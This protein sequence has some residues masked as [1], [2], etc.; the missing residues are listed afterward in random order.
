MKKIGLLIGFALSAVLCPRLSG[1]TNE[2]STALQRGLFEEEANHNFQAALQSYQ[3]AIASYDESRKMAATALYRLGEVYRKLGKTN[4]AAAQYERLLRDFSDQPDLVAAAQKFVGAIAN[5]PTNAAVIAERD[6]DS[7]EIRRLQKLIAETPDLV[8]AGSQGMGNT[9]LHNAAR[10]GHLAVVQ[11]LLTNN[12]NVNAQDAGGRTPLAW[13][14]VST[15]T[16]RFNLEIV[17]ALLKAH[18]DVDLADNWG[19]S[20][21]H[22]AAFVASKPKLDLLLA[23]GANLNRQANN[24]GTP[25]HYAVSRGFRVGIEA[26]LKKGANPNLIA[27][28]RRQVEIAGR[29]EDVMKSDGTPLHLAVSLGFFATAE[30]LIDGGADVN[31]STSSRTTPLHYAVNFRQPAIAKLLLDHNANVDPQTEDGVTPL[32]QAA[33]RADLEM[34]KLLLNHHANPKI[35]N[36]GQVTPMHRIMES[37]HAA[38]STNIIALL[39]DAG[40]DPNAADS[41]GRTPLLSVN[42]EVSASPETLAAMNL[43]L[44]RGANPNSADRG[45]QLTA[46]I[47]AAR[48]ANLPMVKLLLTYHANPNHKSINGLTALHFLCSERSRSPDAPEIA[49]ALITA[50]ANVNAITDYGRTPL[51]VLANA[52]ASGVIPATPMPQPRFPGRPGPSLASQ[53]PPENKPLWDVLVQNGAVEQMADFSKVTSVRGALNGSGELDKDDKG[54]NHFTL[55]ELIAQSYF[56]TDGQLRSPSPV[57][58]DGLLF[59]DFTGVKILRPSKSDPKSTQEIHAYIVTA[60]DAFDCSRDQ[61]LEFGDRVDIPE[62]SHSL[63]SVDSGLSSAQFQSL[64]D[65]LRRTITV[66]IGGQ[67]QDIKLSGTL[68]DTYLASALRLPEIQALLRNTSDL[69]AINVTRVNPKT[70]E[71]Q[72]IAEDITPFWNHQKRFADD[73]WLRAGDKVEVNEKK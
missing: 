73:L 51:S 20:P 6:Y 58:T 45:D 44:K 40:A 60:Q 67:P 27:Y 37:S 47:A 64:K 48:H 22:L 24:G 55:Y 53:A 25:L 33:S 39:L 9:P 15:G 46:I 50:G 8:N 10:L 4:D 62:K 18:A 19:Q 49:R 11:F 71:Q 5:T 30:A 2:I 63:T 7:E 12:V 3:S 41:I 26:L 42:Y 21:L 17:D 28:S 61:D 36:S 29:T 35:A 13:A 56:S 69:T 32:S 31:V 72:K 59:P 68:K 14:V 16:P 52:G 65:C 70:G 66:I 34:V 43:L 23:S 1:V 57:G 38:D 54:L